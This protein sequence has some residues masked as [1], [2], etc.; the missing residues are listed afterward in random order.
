ME[1][2]RKFWRRQR[3]LVTGGH[4]FLGRHV[5]RRLHA[6]GRVAII[7]PS[8]REFDL[9]DHEAVI[10]L[11]QAC[12][13]DD[14]LA[15]GGGGGRHRC[16]P[17]ATRAEFFYD[18]LIMGMHLSTRASSASREVR[19]LG[20]RLLLP[21]VH[22]GS[23][24]GRRSLERLSGRDQRPL[25]TGQEDAARP[26]AGVPCSST[27]STP[28]SC[29]RSTSTARATT[30]TRASSHVIPALIRKC[31]EA[32]D[33][34]AE[35]IEVWGDGSATREFLHVDD[36]ARGILLA[37]ERYND[38]E[39]VNLGSGTEIPIRDLV[40]TIAL[41]V[42]FKGRIAWD[43]SMPNGQ[44]R[45]NLDTSRAETRFGFRPAIDMDEGLR[46]TVAW[47]LASLGRDTGL[48]AT[49]KRLPRGTRAL[50]P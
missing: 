17:G 49:T 37:A 30:S 46:A 29:C 3:I 36:A 19:R 47:Y 50:R 38:G 33:R 41:A 1:H 35:L 13:P 45:R 5:V 10:R 21:Q 4:G 14:C 26:V 2:S 43:P 18:N 23:L 40:D 24:P 12:Q 6:I 9:R 34:G 8:R 22:A 42:G 28:S 15:S 48:Q 25:W 7:A 11:Y 27:D 20:H 44:P 16:E 31:V 32:V 39:P